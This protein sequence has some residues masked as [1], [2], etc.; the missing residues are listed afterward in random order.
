MLAEAI[1]GPI[2]F[3]DLSCQTPRERDSQLWKT[4]NDRKE[5]DM[6]NGGTK[7]RWMGFQIAMLKLQ[8][9]E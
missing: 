6:W 9:K 8:N 2:E 1:F 5:F 7:S 3:C 4:F